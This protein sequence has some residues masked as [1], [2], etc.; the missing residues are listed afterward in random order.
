MAPLRV[1]LVGATPGRG[2]GSAAHLPA[3]RALDEFEVTAVATT[4][5]ES[6]R[7][8]AKAFGIP[9]A[10]A[11]D[12]DLVSSPEVDIVAITVKVPE[13]DALVRAALAAGKHV[14]CEWPLGVNLGQARLLADLAAAS[15]VRHV[16]GLQGYFSPGA[17][18]VA[19]LIADG[20][21]GQLL[22]VSAVTAGGPGGQR[23]PQ[24]SAYAADVAAGATV[25]SISGAHLLATLA[26][27]VGEFRQVSGVVATVNRQA[28]VIETGQTLPVTSPDQ[29]AMSGVL[30]SGAVASVT[31]QGGSAPGGPGFEV[32][33]VGSDA[34]LII[35]PAAAGG[36]IHIAEWAVSVARADGTTEDLPVPER[37]RRVPAA[38]P[39][40]PPR[41][42]A[43]VYA[44]LARAITEGRPAEPDFGTAV[45]YHRL[46]DA[47][48]RASDTGARQ[49][50]G[51]GQ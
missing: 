13:H 30:E 40:G 50:T 3:L 7:A 6:A 16:A 25:L 48:Q 39:A 11:D 38:V 27:A 17:A 43:A 49:D 32:R 26:R 22:S 44:S 42:V 12:S 21:I 29:I 14:F 24:A 41:G 35:R 4:R 33:V 37:L 51:A 31:V 8:T 18:F 23:V 34:T 28:T 46:L 45:R 10:F 19:E 5:I 20:Q 47:I 1:G 9:L 2:W 15:G 36:S